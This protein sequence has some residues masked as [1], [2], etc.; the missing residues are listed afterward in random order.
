MLLQAATPFFTDDAAG[1][2]K[3]LITLVA[4]IVLTVLGGVWKIVHGPLQAEDARLRAHVD[5]IDENLKRDLN[6][7]GTKVNDHNTRHEKHATEYQL[8]TGRV[9]TMELEQKYI[10]EAVAEFRSTVSEFRETSVENK[11]AIVG[12]FSRQMEL[13]RHEVREVREKMIALNTRLDA[14]EELKLLVQEMV[15]RA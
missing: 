13:I 2:I 4:P 15:K 6:S 14:R 9:A 3:I 8:L 1:V 12:E 7:L 5:A 11:V 10:R